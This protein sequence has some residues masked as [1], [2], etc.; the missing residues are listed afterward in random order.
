MFE[1]ERVQKDGGFFS[2]NRVGGDVSVTRSI[3]TTNMDTLEKYK[4]M[5]AKPDVHKRTLEEEDDFILLASDGLWECLD[6]R[7]AVSLAR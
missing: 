6:P 4:G 5:T 1:F 3:G 2:D 7:G